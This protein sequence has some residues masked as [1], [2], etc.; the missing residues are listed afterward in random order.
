[1][2]LQNTANLLIEASFSVI[3]TAWNEL[4]TT[5]LKYCGKYLVENTNNFVKILLLQALIHFS[6]ILLSLLW[7]V[8]DQIDDSIVEMLKI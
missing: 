7:E 8:N 3:D 2:S 4:T 1:V 6:V 5:S